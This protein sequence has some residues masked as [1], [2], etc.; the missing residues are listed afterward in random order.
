MEDINNQGTI[1]SRYIIQEKKGSGKYSNVYLVKDSTNN[2][3]Y[4]AKVLKN[5]TPTF[6]NEINILNKLNHVNSP[7]LIRKITSA[8][9]SIERNNT[10]FMLS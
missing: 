7:Y 2:T 3:L 5:P 8:E 1:H 10:T 6:Q 4:A 9:G